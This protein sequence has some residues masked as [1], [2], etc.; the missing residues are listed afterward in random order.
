[1]LRSGRWQRKSLV[2]TVHWNICSSWLPYGFS[3][4]LALMLNVAVWVS[5]EDI[6]RG[7][8]LCPACNKCPRRINGRYC[9]SPCEKW[10]MDRLRQPQQQQQHYPKPPSGARPHL[11]TPSSSPANANWG[12][13]GESSHVGNYASDNQFL[14]PV[15]GGT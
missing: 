13:T 9:G 3:S 14:S 1:M 15:A 12:T 10:D 11:S 6:R 5:R 4:C 8:T 7:A 2:N